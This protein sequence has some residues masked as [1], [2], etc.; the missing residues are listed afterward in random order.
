LAAQESLIQT[1]KRNADAL[2]VEFTEF[3]SEMNLQPEQRRAHE[4]SFG[5]HW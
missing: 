2:K 4:R 5:G 1:K 3:A